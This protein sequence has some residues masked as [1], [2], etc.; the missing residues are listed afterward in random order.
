MDLFPPTLFFFFGFGLIVDI[1]LTILRL[2]G[3]LCITNDL[4]LHPE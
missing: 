3:T 2:F 4:S 1:R